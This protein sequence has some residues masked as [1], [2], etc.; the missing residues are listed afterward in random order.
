M[1]KIILT[2][3]I[4]LVPIVAYLL[5]TQGEKYMPIPALQQL[6][7]IT[8]NDKTPMR[9]YVVEQDAERIRGLSG[10]A[11]IG[12]TEGMLFI[13]PKDD[14]HGIWMKEMNFPL[15][16]MW[17]SADGTI[18]DAYENVRP[19]SYPRVFEPKTPARFVLE[20]N[21]NY[22]DSFNIHVGDKVNIPTSILP[23]DLRPR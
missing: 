17:L 11:S 14:Y 8:F 22:M 18:I 20:V 7:L 6:P 2:L 19:D 10:R 21:A 4:L 16:I 5:Y 12:P 15:D 1:Q 3:A 23:L 9:V 13:F